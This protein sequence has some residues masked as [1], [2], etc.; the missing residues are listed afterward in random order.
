MLDLTMRR[1]GSVISILTRPFFI[2]ALKSP[3]Q[4]LF[5]SKFSYAIIFLFMFFIL[6]LNK[7]IMHDQSENH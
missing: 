7:N 1:G 6:Y 4:A 3:R 5:H 2:A